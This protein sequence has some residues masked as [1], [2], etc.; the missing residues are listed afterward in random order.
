MRILYN[1]SLSSSAPSPNFSHVIPYL[2]TQSSSYSNSISHHSVQA[3][4]SS[5]CWL[6][7]PSYW[8]C[9]VVFSITG[10]ISLNNT[11]CPSSNNNWMPISLHKVEAVGRTLCQ[12]PHLYWGFGREFVWVLCEFTCVSAMLCL[13]DS[14]FLKVS[15]IY[16]SYNLSISFSVCPWALKGECNKDIPYRSEHFKISY[17]LLI[18]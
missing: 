6:I 14:G 10:V 11:D 17:S 1:V 9:S 3:S 7:T 12:Q 4:Q 16:G 15:T 18:C 8:A 5:L 2:S 13:G